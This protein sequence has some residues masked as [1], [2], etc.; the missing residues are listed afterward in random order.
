[1]RH[2][3]GEGVWAALLEGAHERLHP[4]RDVLLR[5]GED[6]SHVLVLLSGLTKVV[7]AERDG[8][9]DLLAF[10][11]PGEL[12]GEMAVRGG[13][14]RLASV[15]TLDPCRV[16]VMP[17]A[18]FGRFVDDHRLAPHLERHAII[19]VRETTEGRHTGEAPQRVAG[20]LVRIADISYWPGPCV[21]EGVELPL[22]VMDL[23]QHL[24][25]SRNTVGRLI[26]QEPVFGAVRV[27]GRGG[28]E[29]GDL[30]AL[31]RFAA[32]ETPSHHSNVTRVT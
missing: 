28:I 31:R 7:R 16:A 21:R 13:G 27:R 11:G 2:I 12:L 24:K 9:K 14:G 30:P 1:M 6:G 29:I 18:R 4:A 25:M 3:V 10:R 20:A 17:A 22:S 32:R 23:A 15:E 5:Q 8:A 19:R 26:A